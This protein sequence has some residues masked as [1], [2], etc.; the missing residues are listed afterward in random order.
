VIITD[1]EVSITD[2][3]KHLKGFLFFSP[4][5]LLREDSHMFGPL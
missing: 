2:T 1:G 4:D 5:T 3:M